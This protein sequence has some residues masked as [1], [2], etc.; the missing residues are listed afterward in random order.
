MSGGTSLTEQLRGLAR[1]PG[2]FRQSELK[3]L[4]IPEMEVGVVGTGKLVVS[5]A[6]SPATSMQEVCTVYSEIVL[7]EEGAFELPAG[8]P[9]TNVYSIAVD[10]SLRPLLG[11]PYLI[12]RRVHSC[13]FWTDNG[14]FILHNLLS[15]FVRPFNGQGFIL[16]ND[17]P[18]LWMPVFKIS[19]AL[20]N[21]SV[22][23]YV[24][25]LKA[26]YGIV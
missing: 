4:V 1:Q 18:H 15:E 19:A 16:Y 24:D 6:S 8:W 3:P 23:S 17:D 11:A 20:I 26:H 10:E 9:D 14:Q 21:T 12:Q 25:S 22:E 7:Q 13:G 2:T 5:G